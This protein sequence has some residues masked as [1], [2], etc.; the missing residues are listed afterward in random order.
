MPLAV[1]SI[2]NRFA[3]LV[4]NDPD[5]KY[6][7]DN[8]GN[9]EN[10][11]VASSDGTFQA[12]FHYLDRAI[13]EEMTTNLGVAIDS[14][15][16]GAQTIGSSETVIDLDSDRVIDT[17]YFS[18]TGGVV[19]ISETGR[20]RIDTSMSFESTT[21]NQRTI[22]G[23]LQRDNGNGTWTDVPGTITVTSTQKSASVSTGRAIV[24]GAA[25]E[26]FRAVAIETGGNGADTIPESVSMTITAIK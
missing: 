8:D 16:T 10:Y 20:Y 21:G 22:E 25:G 26:K 7:T 15:N 18:R 2:K 1:D 13:V 6:D 24:V 14:Y 17:A 9:D 19:T 12:V 5:D 3:D 11:R 4:D 23:K